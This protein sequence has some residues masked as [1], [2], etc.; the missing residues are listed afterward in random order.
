MDTVQRL[1]VDPCFSM[2]IRGNSFACEK[3]HKFQLA[4]DFLGG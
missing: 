1:R 2:K 3:N 4:W